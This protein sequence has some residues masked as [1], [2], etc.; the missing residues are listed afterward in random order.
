MLVIQIQPI[1][2]NGDHIRVIFR[3]HQEEDIR[4]VPS[5]NLPHSLDCYGVPQPTTV[6]GQYD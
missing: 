2:C 3:L 4:G 6:P 1:Q 5:M